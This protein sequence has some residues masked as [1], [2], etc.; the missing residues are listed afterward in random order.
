[1]SRANERN[2]SGEYAGYD[3]YKNF[4]FR[5]KLDGR[6]VAGFSQIS[7]SA[8][9]PFSGSTSVDQQTADRRTPE[10]IHETCR[11]AGDLSCP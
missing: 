8:G 11:S 1:M 5:V 6:K 3:P 9:D 4:K 10:R 2:A 7:D